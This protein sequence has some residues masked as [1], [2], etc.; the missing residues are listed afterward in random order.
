MKTENFPTFLIILRQFSENSSI[1]PKSV[2]I[3]LIS[4]NL[5]NWFSKNSSDRYGIISI[6]S[7]DFL[8]GRCVQILYTITKFIQVIKP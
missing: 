1:I 8:E 6:G 2:R 3:K 4:G 5:R 7:N